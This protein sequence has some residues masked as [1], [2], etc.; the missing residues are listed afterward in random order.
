M[1]GDDPSKE[2]L[3]AFLLA[4]LRRFA[5][6]ACEPRGPFAPRLRRLAARA[7]VSAYRDCVAQGLGAEARRVVDR[8]LFASGWRG[9]CL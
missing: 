5:A 6:L 9:G 3:G 2:E 8:A 7:T 1:N 4:R